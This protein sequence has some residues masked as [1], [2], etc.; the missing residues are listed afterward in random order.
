MHDWDGVAYLPEA[1]LVG[2]ASG[3]FASN[4]VPT[5]APLATSEAFIATYQAPRG[6]LFN[7][8]ETEV[9]WA[10]SLWPAVHNA[11]A[12]YRGRSAAVA[13]SALAQ[14]YRA[15]LARTGA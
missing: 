2:A 4:E 7:A 5:L 11:R 13:G 1:A 15:R 3:A 10:A 8:E 12:E 14:Q 6:R 9:A